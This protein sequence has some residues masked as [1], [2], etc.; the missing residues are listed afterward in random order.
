[1]PH[2]RSALINMERRCINHSFRIGI[3]SLCGLGATAKTDAV[4]FF[5][6][7]LLLIKFAAFLRCRECF[8]LSFVLVRA[9]PFFSLV[10]E[11]DVL[12]S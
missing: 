2:T 4:S 5:Y 11:R 10:T 3:H 1:M 6:L 9:S 12:D 7:I 8:P